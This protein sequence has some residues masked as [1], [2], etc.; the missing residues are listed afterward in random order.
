MKMITSA[1]GILS[2]LLLV[3]PVFAQSSRI[4]S[5]TASH[6]QARFGFYWETRLNPATPALSDIYSTVVADGPGLFHRVLLDPSRQIYVG[7]DV[8]VKALP[9]SLLTAASTAATCVLD[10]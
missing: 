10:V 7:Y 6:A 3:E 8:V 2:L 4:D 1:M 5:G 9:E